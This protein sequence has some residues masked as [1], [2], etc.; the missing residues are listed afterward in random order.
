MVAGI[1]A[2]VRCDGATLE[3]CFT[4]AG[5]PREL[6]AGFTAMRSAFVLTRNP[7]LA[8]LL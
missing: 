7:V 3:M 5:S 6:V 2:V 4:R 8:G 1:A